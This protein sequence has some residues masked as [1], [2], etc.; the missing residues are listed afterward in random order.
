MAKNFQVGIY[1]AEKTLYEGQAT[2]LIVPSQS[3]YL[4]ILADH[5]PV[6]AKLKAGKITLRLSIGSTNVL[7]S[8][9]GGF[10]E[11][12]RNQVTLLL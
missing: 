10:L 9:A 3:G 6:V 7:E 11:I 1:S 8:S 12:L 5:A 4:G 2:S